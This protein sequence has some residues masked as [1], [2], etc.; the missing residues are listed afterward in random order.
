MAEDLLTFDHRE[1]DLLFDRVFECLDRSDR[2]ETYRSLDLFWAR[3]AMHIRAEHLH[4]FPAIVRYGDES[5]REV[6]EGLRADHD[7]FMK[8]LAAV[9]KLLRAAGNE[10]DR[11][12]LHERLTR[13]RTRLAVH[14]DAEEERIYPA[15]FL[16]DERHIAD[17]LREAILKELSNMPLRFRG[18]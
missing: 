1:L 13:V 18:G 17:G 12:F 6:I 3:L 2:N 8:E 11:D 16:G 14:N 7:F 4:L 5:L 9:I 10:W 15:R